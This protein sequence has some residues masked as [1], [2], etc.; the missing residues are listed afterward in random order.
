MGGKK[1][2]ERKLK[3]INFM[4][5]IEIIMV[6]CLLLFVLLTK[7]SIC[8]VTTYKSLFLFRS[9]SVSIGDSSE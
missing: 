1:E 2:L 9:F 7:G 8:F 5:I 6:F 4:R 3:V